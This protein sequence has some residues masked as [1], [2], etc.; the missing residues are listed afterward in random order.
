MKYSVIST[1]YFIVGLICIILLDQSAFWPGFIAKALIIPVLMILFFININILSGRLHKFMITGLLFS[2]A[3]DVVLELSKNNDNLFIVGLACFLIAHIMYLTA[4]F[5]TPGKNS[6]LN[7]R[8][9]LLIPVL[10]FGIILVSYLYTDLDG[11][12]LPV[13]LYTL[14]ILSML[15]GALNR[16]DKVKKFSFYLVLAGAILFVISDSVI[17]FN[18]FVH[19][20]D[21]SGI[22]I[23]S[24]Y[25][26]AQY[27]IVTGYIF[28]FKPVAGKYIV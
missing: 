20:F 14:V 9:Y 7:N 24:T 8:F 12:R 19:Q 1:V 23:M 10:I 27:L 18:K 21:S 6:I 2:W 5:L 28:Q 22:V 3:G 11:M 15:A 17:A 13:I 25:I 26:I 16:I 4:F